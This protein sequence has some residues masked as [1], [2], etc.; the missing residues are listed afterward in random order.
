MGNIWFASDT[1]FTSMGML[2]R[3]NRPFKS[4]Y[5]YDKYV[6]KLWNE[7]VEEE[8]EIYHL[9][10]F[11]DYTGK[12]NKYWREALNY[13]QQ[14]KCNV[15]LI[16]GDMEEKVIQDVYGDDFERFQE[17]CLSVGFKSVYRD[18]YLEINGETYY[19]NHFP[20]KHKDGCINLF[21][22]IHRATGFYKPYGLNLSIDLNHFYL[23]DIN[24]VNRLWS[25]RG[26]IESC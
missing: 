23:Y 14:I 25:A 19:L 12:T 6:L 4:V 20:T 10:D 1:H 17:Y 24:E 3:E 21:G 26:K 8:D 22:H 2:V 7:Q 13:V 5:A 11:I 9:G 15:T 16:I 18:K